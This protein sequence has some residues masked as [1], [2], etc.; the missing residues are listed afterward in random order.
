MVQQ[1]FLAHAEEFQTGSKR[2][3]QLLCCWL[4]IYDQGMDGDCKDRFYSRSASGLQP[5]FLFP[6]DPFQVASLQAAILLFPFELEFAVLCGVHGC[7]CAG[8]LLVSSL[9]ASRM[10]TQFSGGLAVLG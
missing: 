9:E 4:V 5:A 3:E 8:V 6:A 2:A 7:L 10:G 1:G